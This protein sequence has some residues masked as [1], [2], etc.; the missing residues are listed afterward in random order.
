MYIC[1][2]QI[3][4][5]NHFIYMHEHIHS[6]IPS[7][8]TIN[9]Y[10]TFNPKPASIIFDQSQNKIQD[11]PNNLWSRIFF[12]LCLIKGTTQCIKRAVD[13]DSSHTDWV[14][15]VA[16]FGPSEQHSVAVEAQVAGLGCSWTVFSLP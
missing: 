4:A 9:C 3:C 5:L 12:I 6:F 2:W 15:F 14:P 11:Y 10:D 1:L 8:T 16:A 7:M 13:W